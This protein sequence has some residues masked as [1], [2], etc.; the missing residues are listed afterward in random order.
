MQRYR[1]QGWKGIV[2]LLLAF[3]N[4]IISIKGLIFGIP[5]YIGFFSDLYKYNKISNSKEIAILALQPELFDKNSNAGI[6]NEL[7]Y[8][9]SWAIRV[10]LENYP[11]IHVDVGSETVFLGML[12]SLMKV[13]AID[14][15]PFNVNL[16]GL[17]FKRGDILH[18][19]Y[20][21]ETVNS[22]SCLH[23]IEHI[24]L[25]RYGDKLDPD[26]S[27]KAVKELQRVLSP[28]GNLYI[29]TAI[30]RPRIKFNSSRV[31]SPEYIIKIFDQLELIELSGIDPDN[32]FQRNIDINLLSTIEYGIGLFHFQ[33]PIA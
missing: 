16:E 32:M 33:K 2:N 24:G 10:I 26:G 22:L 27:V 7:F 18:L 23:T 30:G 5:K 1:P 9:N 25:G 4:P 28:G 17:N 13:N 11:K 31:F 14:I 6:G 21:D 29:S 19:P 8:Q 3:I 15:R 12:S 20:D